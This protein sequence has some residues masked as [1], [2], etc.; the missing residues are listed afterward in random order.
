[1]GLYYKRMLALNVLFGDELHH[2]E[3]F[4]ALS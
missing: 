3:R 1:V 2:T 4:A